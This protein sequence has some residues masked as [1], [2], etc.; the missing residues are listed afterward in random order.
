LKQALEYK[1]SKDKGKGLDCVIKR[2]RGREGGGVPC[3]E[4]H[5]VVEHRE[6]D[7]SEPAVVLVC[8]WI[9]DPDLFPENKNGC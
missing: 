4:H 2:M 6:S 3:D 8:C 7:D 5:E 9:H 1:I